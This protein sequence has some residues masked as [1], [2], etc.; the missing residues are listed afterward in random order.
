MQPQ[1]SQ[2]VGHPPAGYL[3]GIKAQEWRKVLLEVAVGKPVEVEEENQQTGQQGLNRGVG[4]AQSGGLPFQLAMELCSGAR[5]VVYEA[6]LE[7]SAV[8]RQLI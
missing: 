4:E 2:L 7:L 6:L 5:W 1:P 3:T 8:G